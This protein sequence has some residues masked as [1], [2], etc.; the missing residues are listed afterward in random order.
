[1]MRILPAWGAPLILVVLL[2]GSACPAKDPGPR[3]SIP[4]AIHGI[5]V[6]RLHGTSVS[7]SEYRGKVLLVVNT[8]SQCGY[9]QQYE[10]LER[11]Y[12]E[13]QGRGVTVLG[14]PSNDFGGQEPGSA[15]EIARFCKQRYGVT[16]PLFEKVKTRGPEQSP[17]YRFLTAKHG[18]P[19]WNFSQVCPWQGRQ[20][21]KILRDR[22]DP[23]E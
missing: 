6:N 12:K 16:F 8:A 20:G 7:L 18:G 11:L 9:T 13:Y 22:G 3:E 23:G 17:V 10:G 5:S 15:P 14:F 4:A 2:W 19:Q 21:A 1:M